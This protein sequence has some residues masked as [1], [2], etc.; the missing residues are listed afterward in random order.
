[1]PKLRPIT[2]P[3]PQEHLTLISETMEKLLE[4]VPQ[5]D[6][7]LRI[8][9]YFQKMTVSWVANRSFFGMAW[10]RLGSVPPAIELSFHMLKAAGPVQT[11]ETIQHEV[12][13]HV[14]F[15]VFSDD[16]H[17]RGWKQCMRWLGLEP[18]R[19]AAPPPGFETR[20]QKRLPICCPNGHRVML[21]SRKF[22]RVVGDMEVGRF[23]RCGTCK[24]QLLHPLKPTALAA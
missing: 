21:T 12:C 3:M 14:A 1:M 9:N 13:H 2:E 4:H 6:K 17:G 24:S 15:L 18:N 7:K 20:R 16:G 23:W 19:C 5:E 22:N 10:M 8:R 11:S